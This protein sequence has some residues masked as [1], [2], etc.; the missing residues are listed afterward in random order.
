MTPS[1]LNKLSSSP[2]TLMT[3]YWWHNYCN[4]PGKRK[5]DTYLWGVLMAILS[6]VTDSYLKLGMLYN[7]RKHVRYLSPLMIMMRLLMKCTGEYL[8]NCSNSLMR[9]L[10][11][12][13]S[14]QYWLL[15]IYPCL[16]CL[17]GWKR[18]N[19]LLN[20]KSKI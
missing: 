16:D 14:Y 7:H 11:N 9:L 3:G 1:L 2:M 20:P 10:I 18:W 15:N 19:R 6:L 4:P 12:L 17:I 5:S 8:M 13:S